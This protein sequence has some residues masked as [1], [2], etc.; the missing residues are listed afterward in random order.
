MVLITKAL[1][2][3]R[4]KRVSNAGFVIPPSGPPGPTRLAPYA[5]ICSARCFIEMITLVA[6]SISRRPGPL[7]VLSVRP[8]TDAPFFRRPPHFAEPAFPQRTDSRAAAAGIVASGGRYRSR[9]KA[10]SASNQAPIATSI[11]RGTSPSS[12]DR[13]PCR[14]AAGPARATPTTAALRRAERVRCQDRDRAAARRPTRQMSVLAPP[15]RAAT[16]TLPHSLTGPHGRPLLLEAIPQ[17]PS[18][19]PVRR[20]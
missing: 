4:L 19:L 20:A 6:R 13:A 7:S 14:A 12:P 3:L 11:H 17:T 8:V 2:H 5:S 18:Q 1:C 15:A 16:R 9:F 10:H